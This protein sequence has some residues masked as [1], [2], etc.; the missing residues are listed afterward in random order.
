M[1]LQGI[2]CQQYG[3]LHCNT[4]THT[5]TN[6]HTN[7][8]THTQYGAAG[9]KVSFIDVLQVRQGESVTHALCGVGWGLGGKLAEESETLRHAFGPARY[10]VIYNYIILYIYIHTYILIYVYVYIN[11]M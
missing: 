2:R 7:T 10:L 5:H 3:G 4:H 11:Y 9:H 8:H 6:T 1:G